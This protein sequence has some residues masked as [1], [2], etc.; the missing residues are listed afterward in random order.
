MGGGWRSWMPYD[1]S[2]RVG[3]ELYDYRTDPGERENVAGKAS[4]TATLREM[5]GLMEEYF[6]SQVRK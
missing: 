3:V 2:K 4:M 1:A 6:R 5:Q